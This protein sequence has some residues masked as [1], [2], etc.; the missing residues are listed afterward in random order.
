MSRASL[1][2]TTLVQTPRH[3]VEHGVPTC[4]LQSRVI[5]GSAKE[6]QCCDGGA[7][8]SRGDGLEE[9]GGGPPH[10]PGTELHAGSTYL[11]GARG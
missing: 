6:R 11:T 8:K 10:S 5:D 7:G 9:G 1:A 4:K 2:H 3:K